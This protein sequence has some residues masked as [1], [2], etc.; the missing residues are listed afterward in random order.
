MESINN[1]QFV[2]M[3]DGCSTRQKL[4]DNIAEYAKIIVKSVELSGVE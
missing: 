1:G 4:N 2:H 3:R